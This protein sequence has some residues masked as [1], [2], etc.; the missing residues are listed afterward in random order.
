MCRS[1]TTRALTVLVDRIAVTSLY[2]R[3]LTTPAAKGASSPPGQ[4]AL[5]ALHLSY[6]RLGPTYKPD[7]HVLALTELRLTLR[8]NA[9]VVDNSYWL[10]K[11]PR[12][13]I[14]RRRR[15]ERGGEVEAARILMEE[16]VLGWG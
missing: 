14:G 9:Y 16:D 5:L 15:R 7:R 12:E 10:S 6:H 3:L 1:A 11:V 8:P 2:G 4:P 13:G